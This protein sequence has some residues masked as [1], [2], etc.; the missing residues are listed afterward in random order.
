M[1]LSI[2]MPHE[3]ERIQ[4]VADRGDARLRLDQV[5][6]RRVSD[7]SRLSRSAAQRWIETGAVLIDGRAARRA[8]AR[9]RE[10]ATVEVV[11][12]ESA[13]RRVRPA[14]EAVDLDVVYEDDD[15]IVVNK[16]A[17][18]VVHPSYK[19]ITGTLLSGVLWRLRDRTGDQPGG[20]QPGIVTRLDKGTSGLVVV[21]L[22]P[23]VHAAL[24]RA[25]V[26]GR[27]R[28]EYLAV[29]AASPMPSSGRITLPLARDPSDRRR[30]VTMSGGAPSETRY[31]V[32]ST[33]RDGDSALSV[34]RCE[35]ITGRTHQ[36]R[37][38]L[39]AS[40]WPILG[41]PLYGT[42]HPGIARQALHAWRLSMP[43]PVTNEPLVF[44][45]PLPPDMAS[46]VGG[47]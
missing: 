46:L 2:E 26:A 16:P 21:A 20:K 39:A 28:K 34:V 42:P 31:D 29:V 10:G 27:V 17:G 36:I 32:I 37:V 38:H 1:V 9:V 18:V 47:P 24:Q 43:H 6:V 23:A 19:Q 12:P 44:E 3:L 13:V 15:L 14:A 45:A 40:G 25:S 33:R 4:F 5:V 35:L 11:L 7:V 8:A 41:D 22:T 30:V